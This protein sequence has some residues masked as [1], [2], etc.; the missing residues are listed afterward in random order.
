MAYETEIF[1]NLRFFCVLVGVRTASKYVVQGVV[2]SFRLASR[3]A[4]VAGFSVTLDI[5]CRVFRDGTGLQ[6][7]RAARRLAKNHLNA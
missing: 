1:A 7:L 3:V 6:K 5:V 4:T 2:R